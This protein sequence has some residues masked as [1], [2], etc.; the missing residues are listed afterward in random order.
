MP[1]KG[2]YEDYKDNNLRHTEFHTTPPISTTQVSIVMT[3][4]PPIRINANVSLWCEI[5][6]MPK[7]EKYVM[8]AMQVIENITLHLKSE[9]KE[10][11]IPKMDH[12]AIQD[13]PYSD[14]SKWGLIFYR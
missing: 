14:T 13:F 5:C 4:L 12:V 9:F 11:A 10:I 3:D 8:Y 6:L 2:T 1:T 7:Y